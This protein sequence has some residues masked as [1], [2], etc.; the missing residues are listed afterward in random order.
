MK[1]QN[2]TTIKA[3]DKD[4]NMHQDL[5]NYL[6]QLVQQLQANLSDQGYLLPQQTSANIATLNTPQSTGAFVYDKET[7]E[8]KVNIN[9]TFKTVQVA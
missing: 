7:H 8:V 9:G 4:G 5:V 6:G 3:A 2:L 1:F